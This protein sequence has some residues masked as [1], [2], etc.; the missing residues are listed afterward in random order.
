MARPKD[1]ELPDGTRIPICYEDRSVLVIDKPAGWL[2]A[3]DDW[4]NT[5][6][7][8]VLALRSSLENG[9][10]WAQSR[11]LRF[12][13]LVHRL[14]AE[15]SGLLMGV[16][17]PGAV[18]AYSQLF[19]GRQ[20][21]KTY[22]AVVT[23]PVPS[24]AWTRTDP[25]GPD[26]RQ[27]GRFRVDARDGKSAETRFRV[28]A[29]G[30]KSTL[31]E[32]RP[33]TGRTHQIRLHLQASGCPVLGDDLYGRRDVRG[34]AL[35]AAGLGYTDPFQKRQIRI[36][37]PIEAFCRTFG[38]AVPDGWGRA[39]RKEGESSVPTARAD[40]SGTRRRPPVTSSTDE[41]GRRQANRSG[42]RGPS[43]GETGQ[44]S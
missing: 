11:N 22:L 33:V 23:G 39:P 44:T 15:T 27:Q 42:P 21:E 24:D 4:V 20:L 40:D 19:E 18:A 43:A 30:E 12:L 5:R 37:A 25:L 1:I 10:W 17:S 3:P 34:L 2:V 26:D 41:T 7:N 8:L 9:D 38:F 13:R 32:A 31:L 35:R 28:L 14:D 16:K 6:R 29:R 36:R